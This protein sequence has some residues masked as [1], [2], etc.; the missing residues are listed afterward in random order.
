M[1]CDTTATAR[2]RTLRDLSI[3]LPPRFT[4]RSYTLDDTSPRR[5]MPACPP[6][7]H[8]PFH[9]LYRGS[10]AGSPSTR[11]LLLSSPYSCR[12]LCDVSCVVCP[13][14]P[15]PV[16]PSTLLSP[17]LL[18]NVAYPMPHLFCD[19]LLMPV[20][21]HTIFTTDRHLLRHGDTR[22]LRVLLRY[23]LFV[24][25]TTTD[26]AFIYAI[27]SPHHYIPCHLPIVPDRYTAHLPP[28]SVKRARP[29]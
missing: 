16:L 8:L 23:K 10:R 11:F 9:P 21:Y 2:C 18:V 15:L 26:D 17:L 27:T 1:R 5:W 3:L 29:Y 24:P 19:I 20:R 25:A 12:P 13:V 22:T 6:S 14:P 4:P 7:P 28:C